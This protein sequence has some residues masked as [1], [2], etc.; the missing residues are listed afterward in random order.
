MAATVAMQTMMQ[1]ILGFLHQPRY[2]RPALALYLMEEFRL[3][4]ADSVVL[5]IVNRRW[6][7]T[8]AVA[9]SGI[10]RKNATLRQPRLSSILPLTSE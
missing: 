8:R 7:L 2:G 10:K 4:I 1:Q 5:N 3:I 6:L 9:R